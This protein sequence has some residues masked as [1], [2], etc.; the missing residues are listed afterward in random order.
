VLL[1]N[2]R[3][4]HGRD[5]FSGPRTVLRVLGDPLPGTGIMPGFPWPAHPAC[6]G[7]RPG[8]GVSRCSWRAGRR[9][10]YRTGPRGPRSCCWSGPVRR[11]PG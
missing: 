6:T 7:R 9:F 10:G 1:S 8:A 4:L 3:W 2:T 11:G 5:H